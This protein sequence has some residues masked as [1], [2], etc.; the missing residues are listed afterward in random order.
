MH[1]VLRCLFIL[2][3]ED[4]L[5]ESNEAL[6]SLVTS[7]IHDVDVEEVGLVLEEQIA[8]APEPAICVAIDGLAVQACRL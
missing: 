4:G 5:V 1:W 8:V 7:L 3:L 6:V 2:A